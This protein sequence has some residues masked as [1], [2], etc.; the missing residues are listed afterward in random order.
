M[1]SL[2][3]PFLAEKAQK[4]ALTNDF[5]KHVGICSQRVSAI[6]SGRCGATLKEINN[7][8]KFFQIPTAE[9]LKYD[10]PIIK[11]E[12]KTCT[13]CQEQFIPTNARQEFCSD[14]CRNKDFRANIK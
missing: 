10:K 5:Y 6:I 11:M 13:H 12:T 8:A 14:S 3:A 7:V 2:I 4:S 9:I 1:Q